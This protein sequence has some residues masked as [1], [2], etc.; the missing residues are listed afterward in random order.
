M[1]L[2]LRQQHCIVI[3][4]PLSVEPTEPRGAALTMPAFEGNANDKDALV[5]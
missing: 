5:R 3:S 1:T 4:S 2:N